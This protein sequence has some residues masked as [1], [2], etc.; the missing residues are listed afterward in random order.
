[1]FRDEIADAISHAVISRQVN[2]S[3]ARSSSNGTLGICKAPCGHSWQV[4]A[5]TLG[6]TNALLHSFNIDITID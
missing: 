4:A 2:K 1:M 5:I 6:G 3:I